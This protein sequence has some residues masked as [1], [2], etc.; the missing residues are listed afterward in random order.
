VG[1]RLVEINLQVRTIFRKALGADLSDSE[2]EA[3]HAIPTRGAYAPSTFA[4]AA[5]TQ[6]MHPQPVPRVAVAQ[7][8]QA[9]D[10]PVPEDPSSADDA[11]EETAPLRFSQLAADHPFFQRGLGATGNM[12]LPQGMQDRA[13]MRKLLLYGSNKLRL[14]KVVDLY[15]VVEVT[16]SGTSKRKK[17]LRP[18]TTQ[19]KKLLTE[20]FEQFP[21]LGSINTRVKDGIIE[22]RGWSSARANQ[23]LF[24]NECMQCAK[25][26]IREV[27]RRRALFHEK[28]AQPSDGQARGVLVAEAAEA[29][30]EPAP[31]TPA[32]GRD[33]V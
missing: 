17:K 23:I 25:I 14:S 32:L 21:R 9:D 1:S 28:S 15:N 2:Q 30:E 11:L 7:P 19:V 6:T 22:L 10:V 5:P 29:P 31:A 13:L 20:A 16:G 3:T 4:A 12:L 33:A 24:H 27:S 8:D 18:S 26:S